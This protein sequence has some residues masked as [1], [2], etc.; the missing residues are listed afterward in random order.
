MGIVY[1]LFG[2]AVICL[3]V[4]LEVQTLGNFWWE[5]YIFGVFRIEEV[6]LLGLVLVI[7][8]GVLSSLLRRLVYKRPLSRWAAGTEIRKTM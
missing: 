2:V 7:A 3:V 5:R 1:K 8:G 6:M 4:V